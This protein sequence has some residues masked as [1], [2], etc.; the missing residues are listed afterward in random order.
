MPK[1]HSYSVSTN[2]T[3]VLPNCKHQCI[4]P[5]TTKVELHRSTGE[6]EQRGQKGNYLSNNVFGRH[7]PLKNNQSHDTDAVLYLN[8]VVTSEMEECVSCN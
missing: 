6:A 3:A 1:S 8:I 5:S 4:M 7:C 2:E